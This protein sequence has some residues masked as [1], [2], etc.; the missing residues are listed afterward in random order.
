MF[1]NVS[2]PP[3]VQ[4]Y[5]VLRTLFSTVSILALPNRAFRGIWIHPHYVPRELIIPRLLTHGDKRDGDER[6]YAIKGRHPPDPN[7]MRRSEARYRN[8]RYPIYVYGSRPTSRSHP[9]SDLGLEV[10]AF[11]LHRVFRAFVRGAAIAEAYA[12]AHNFRP[13]D[14]LVWRRVALRE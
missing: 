6:V 13:S 11:V 2:T 3:A 10:G 9:R 7:R 1:I 4:R 8:T 12:A 5:Y 14:A